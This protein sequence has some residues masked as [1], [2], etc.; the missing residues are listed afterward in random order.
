LRK[1]GEGTI[2]IL[3]IRMK[4]VPVETVFWNLMKLQVGDLI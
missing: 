1:G 3:A 4:D 2:P